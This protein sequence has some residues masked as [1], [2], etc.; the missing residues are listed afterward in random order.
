MDAMQDDGL[1]EQ[2]QELANIYDVQE[3]TAVE[4]GRGSFD[5]PITPTGKG[6]QVW[7]IPSTDIT[8]DQALVEE[9][10]AL[11]PTE[12]EREFDQDISKKRY[13][14]SLLKAF[15]KENVNDTTGAF[16]KINEN[17]DRGGFNLIKYNMGYILFYKSF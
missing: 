3:P 15:I 2:Q 17:T 5:Q 11:V 10:R 8:Y 6:K 12:F 16:Y 9:A 13:S 4:E 7:A 14:E 1:D